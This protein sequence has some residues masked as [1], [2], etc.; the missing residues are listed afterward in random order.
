MGYVVT[1]P[2]CGPPAILSPALKRWGPAKRQGL[3]RHFAH[4][5]ATFHFVPALTLL[6]PS[7]QQRLCRHPM[8]LWATSDFVARS[9]VWDTPPPRGSKGYEAT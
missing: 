5:C 1:N 6:G 9:S 7:G 2:T 8:S 3:R 4:L